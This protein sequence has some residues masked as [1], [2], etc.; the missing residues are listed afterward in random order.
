M[1][2]GFPK[3][4]EISRQQAADTAM[5][6]ALILLLAALSLERRWAIS[7]AAVV[8]VLGMTVPFAFR[9]VAVLWFGLAHALG[10][11]S[12][13]VVLCVLFFALVVP[14]GVA[15][16]LSGKDALALRRYRAGSESLFTVRNK[17]YRARDLIHPY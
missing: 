4:R 6:V 2:N 5:A 10:A 11:V 3:A 1:M 9:Y 8:L 16:R 15:R 12:S 13:R 17:R 14:I 7:T